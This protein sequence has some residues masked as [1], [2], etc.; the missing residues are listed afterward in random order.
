MENI[1]PKIFKAYDIRGIYPTDINEENI[2]VIISAIYT[3]FVKD[4]QKDNLTVVV[5]QD[6][7]ISSPG[8]AKVTK[9]TLVS[10]GAWVIDIGLAGTP[11]FY[12]A[13]RSNKY[14]AGIQISASHNPKEYNGLKIV[15]NTPNG[16][17]K[18]GKGTGMEKIKEI[19]EAKEYVLPK[20]GG[21]AETREG[22][23]DLEIE[24]AIK[25]VNPQFLKPLRVVADTAN[26]MG[27]LY[28]EALFKKIPGSLSGIN[29]TL[30]GTFPAHQA[31]P[32]QFE[33]LKDLQKYVLE[34]KADL[35]IAPD[36]DA[37][38]T[39]F[40]DETGKVVSAS[41]ITSLVI[42][43]FLKKNPGETIVC[44]IR[45]LMNARKIVKKMGGKLIISRV[46]HALIT[47]T[48]HKNNAFFAGESS[49]H[50][51]F[52]DTGFAESSVS[53]VLTI[54]DILSKE[55][56]PLS[57]IVKEVQSAFESGETN[58]ELDD[59]SKAKP[60]LDQII[61]TYKDGELSML[62]G[63]AIE[64]P[65]WR[66]NVRRSN[67]EPLLRLNLEAERE[68][69]MQEKNKELIDKIISLGGIIKK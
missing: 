7:R 49:G 21:K 13:V 34:K 35:G 14:D 45:Y 19:V 15:K 11:T 18:I 62:D 54:L 29:L 65:G 61:E 22:L 53:V 68:S 64:Y 52:R 27:I 58:F 38:R 46:G 33:T 9:D 47:E 40:I 69:V 6:M 24:A 32:F 5:S 25:R 10:L 20:E 31:D 67:T 17:I 28:L 42:R 55:K 1:N 3:F 16:L 8:L 2:K 48:M 37:D 23:V 60:I 50:Y 41:L 30:D 66:F 4:L 51:F 43:E 44:D 39:F 56:K 26:A 63:I 57:G 59:V 36:G 12:F